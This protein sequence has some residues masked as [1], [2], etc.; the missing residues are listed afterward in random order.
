[1]EEKYLDTINRLVEE[2][3]RLTNEYTELSNKMNAE[4]KEEHRKAN[5]KVFLILVGCMVFFMWYYFWAFNGNYYNKTIKVENKAT[6]ESTSKII[7][8]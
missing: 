5:K 1:M 8:N 6:S 3:K 2:N 4:L 7:N